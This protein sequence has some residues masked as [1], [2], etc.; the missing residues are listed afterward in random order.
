MAQ[1]IARPQQPE[2]TGISSGASRFSNE[3]PMAQNTSKTTTQPLTKPSGTSL[4]ELGAEYVID[5]AVSKDSKDN[6]ANVDKLLKLLLSS[7]FFAQVRQG[8]P[9][10][11][12]VFVKTSAAQLQ[13]LY[14]QLQIRDFLHD[15]RKSIPSEPPSPEELEANLTPAE[16]LR[17]IHSFLTYPEYD[18]GLGITPNHGEWSFVKS[19]FPLQD[20]ELN[21][22]WIK[23]LGSKFIIDDN[24]INWMRDQFGEKVALY[25]AYLQNYFIWLIAPSI[26]GILTHY[27]VGSFSMIFGIVNVLWSILF[28]ANWERKE[29]ILA[30]RWGVKGCSKLE[31]V[32]TSFV[33]E[34]YQVDYVTGVKK[35]SYPFW[36]RFVKE[37]ASIPLVLGAMFAVFT[38]QIAALTLETFIVQVYQGPLKFIFKLIPTV[39]L[40]AIVPVVVAI[41]KIVANRVLTFENHE[42]EDSY[43]LSFNQKIFSVSFWTS[44]G[45]LFLTAYLYLPFGH[46]LIPHLDNVSLQFNTFVGASY[47]DGKTFQIN[48]HRLE[49]QV[50]YLMV[51]GQIINF[52]VEIIVPWAQRTAFELLDKYTNKAPPVF[53]DSAEEHE[54][55]KS[56]RRQANSP[57]FNASEEYQEMVTQFSFVTVFGVAWSLAPLAS[58]VNNWFEL[59]GDAFKIFRDTKRP[60]PARE[61]TIGPWLTDLKYMTWLGSVVT[62]SLV[63][64]YGNTYTSFADLTKRGMGLVAISPRVL[65]TSIIAAEHLYFLI[66]KIVNFAFSHYPS[67]EQLEDRKQEYLIRKRL[68]EGRL[69]TRSISVDAALT[70]VEIVWK[71]LSNPESQAETAISATILAANPPPKKTSE[72]REKSD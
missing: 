62:T 18:H 49:Q 41:Y 70:P 37:I 44:T 38:L 19:I 29:K 50:I 28:V 7:G 39:V 15:I 46:L 45:S 24:E 68:V 6:K 25:F 11:V 61:D 55:L 12:F 52:A 16:K 21:K 2:E 69:E 27:V 63:L 23:R 32:R 33:P 26:I 56:V 9:G 57:V 43:N 8:N 1:P 60:I 71:N 22:K 54:F 4:S 20:T 3:K 65:L 35:P 53:Q 59:R 67:K 5:V 17:L 40:A 64:M 58:L 34:S 72:S 10:T 42:T 47:A 14:V 30:L 51:T 13:S 48:G 36:K 31:S 66:C